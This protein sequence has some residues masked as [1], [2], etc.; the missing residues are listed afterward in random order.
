[1]YCYSRSCDASNTLD[2]NFYWYH[3]CPLVPSVVPIWHL[4]NCLL[5]WPCICVA[6]LLQGREVAWKIC[7]KCIWVDCP[8]INND[9]VWINSALLSGYLNIPNR[10]PP[11]C[12]DWLVQC[13]KVT[14]IKHQDVINSLWFF[15]QWL[16][17]VGL[18]FWAFAFYRSVCVPTCSVDLRGGT[19]LMPTV[20]LTSGG[21]VLWYIYLYTSLI[22]VFLKEQMDLCVSSVLWRR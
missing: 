17:H 16:M 2:F 11:S 21:W 12:I 8:A 4:I 1:M 3:V 9:C 20:F 18:T 14:V 7:R 22:I 10:L 15:K 6:V 13:L 19:Q 5:A